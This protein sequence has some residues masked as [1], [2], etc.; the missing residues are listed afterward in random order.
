M[1]I[2]KSHW[3]GIGFGF[4]VL[5]LALFFIGENMFFFL[6]GMG[7]IIVAAPFVLSTITETKEENEK[8]EMFLEF[9]RN[10]VES[11]KT[12]VPISRS[13]INIKDKNFGILSDHIKKLAN[14]IY[15]GIPLGT[16]L[17]VF[18]EDVKNKTISRAITLIGQAEKSGGEIEEI[19]ESVAR[20][21][22]TSDNLK[23]ERKALISSL[24][25]QGY[26]I[27][28]VFMIII[29]V[30]QFKIIPL[31]SEVGGAGISEIGS[32]G[33]GGET[34]VGT[35][36]IEVSNAFFYL[37]II[38]GLFSGLTVGKLAEKNFKAGIKHSFILMIL[39]FMVSSTANF[40]FG[41]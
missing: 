14:Q 34:N 39:A 31:I 27:F 38:Q 36:E 11:G 9:A 22:S 2:K 29:L 17:K 32:F 3:F 35:G 37:L 18:S 13:I 30:L 40:F 8:E 25:V 5:V 7:M 6:I 20:A 28:F 16:A 19:L 4:A 15:I 26:I 10:L 33:I 1:D 23:K 21:V 12:G 24:I 41:G